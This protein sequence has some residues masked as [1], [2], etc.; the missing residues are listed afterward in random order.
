MEQMI[1]YIHPTSNFNLLFWHSFQK[2]RLI[3]GCE[4]FSDQSFK[5]HV[6]LNGEL[7]TLVIRA[8]DKGLIEVNCTG[9]FNDSVAVMLKNRI[10]K[11]LDIVTDSHV[12]DNILSNQT[13]ALFPQAG[14]KIPGCF[15]IYE[16]AVRAVLGQQVS[17]K[18][19]TELVSMFAEY[20][21]TGSGGSF[22]PE[23]EE[24]FPLINKIADRLPVTRNKRN[25]L[26]EI[27][28]FLMANNQIHHVDI[29][30][31]RNIKGVGSWTIGNIKLRGML[32][33]DILLGGDLIIRKVCK[34][35]ALPDAKDPYYNRFSPYR[36]Y[37][38]LNLWHVYNLQNHVYDDMFFAPK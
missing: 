16:S 4:F 9:R 7:Y 1:F 3:K 12:I 6:M 5:K 31:A 25:A 2:R 38:T 32:D 15:S 14:I 33:P 19:A 11:M 20:V 13:Q 8:R 37:L 34:Q 10:Y 22:F 36:S 26:V 30:E 17:I 24:A 35:L 29:N 28:E 18:R 23:K 27:T 21:S